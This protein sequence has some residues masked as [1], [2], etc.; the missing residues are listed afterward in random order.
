MNRAGRVVLRMGLRVPFLFVNASHND[1]R[2]G[3]EQLAHRHPGLSG[4]HLLRDGRDAFAARLQLAES[5]RQSIDCQCYIWRNDMSG[6]LLFD[7]LLRAARRGVQVRLLLDDH[8]TAG[9][10]ALLASLDAQPNFE[11]RLFNPHRLRRW[12]ILGLLWD[13]ARLNR[14]MHNKSFTVDGVAT[15]VGGRNVGD[16]YFAADAEVSFVDVDVLAVGQVVGGVQ[17]DFE[18]YWISR[19]AVPASRVLPAVSGA[20]LESMH[21]T[22]QEII[23][24][25]AARDYVQAIVASTLTRG[26]QDGTLPLAWARARVISDPPSKGLKL[27]GRRKLL[28][29]RLQRI[30]GSPQRELLIISAYFVPTRRAMRLLLRLAERGVRITVLTNSLEATDVAAVH[31]GYARYRRRLLRAGIRLFE[32][33]RQGGAQVGVPNSGSS[34]SN[35]HAKVFSVDR[36]RVFVGSFNFDA[37]SAFLNTEMGV[38]IDSPELAEAI[39]GERMLQRLPAEAYLVRRISG[40]PLQWIEQRDGR[41][42]VHTREPNAGL[43]RRALVFVLSYLRIEWLL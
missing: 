16:E 11:V 39:A 9:L 28:V 32:M 5:A 12:R 6:M 37:R 17:R 35:L 26:M 23:H 30:L 20:T 7:A 19:S 31:A 2:P 24:A 40:R 34:A 41:E 38:A 36:K 8:N 42:I 43:G 14:R 18:G 13:F 4:F 25:D 3:L 27:P 10:D 15:I 33:K 29:R 22:A 1:L 21:R